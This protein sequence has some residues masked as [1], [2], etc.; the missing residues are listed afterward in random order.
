MFRASTMEKVAQPSNANV[1]INTLF[2]FRTK[3]KQN[4]THLPDYLLPHIESA[5]NYSKEFANSCISLGRRGHCKEGTF[6]SAKYM[7][8]IVSLI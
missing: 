4:L 7:E 5:I 1:G 3:S 8:Q 6:R 2:H